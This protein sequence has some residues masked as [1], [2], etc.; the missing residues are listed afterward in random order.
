MVYRKIK[1]DMI[2]HSWSDRLIAKPFYIYGKN[3]DRTHIDVISNRVKSPKGEQDLGDFICFQEP[4]SETAI[5]LQQALIEQ[6][7]SRK[8][9]ILA[10]RIQGYS[11][12]EIG[13]KYKL[14]VARVDQL[15]ED[16]KSE[17][18]KSK[19]IAKDPLKPFTRNE[20]RVIGANMNIRACE[21]AEVLGKRVIDV[22]RLKTSLSKTR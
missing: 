19:Y 1:W 6:R 8:R 2:K 22:Y 21:M 10:M 7:D 5:V 16:I 15:F 9:D 18:K 4:I 17:I 14:G 3:I 11:R 13:S 20:I 12:K